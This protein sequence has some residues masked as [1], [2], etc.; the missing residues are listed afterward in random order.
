MVAK[1][2]EADQ[3]KMEVQQGVAVS[4]TSD[5][6]T[7]VTYLGLTCHYINEKLQLCTFVLGV[8]YFPQSHTAGMM[9]DWAITN[10]VVSCD[11]RS[12]KHDCIH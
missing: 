2:Y 11:R 10:K 1:K 3:V 8:Q 4:I 5:M 9:V 6:W 7:S 12:T